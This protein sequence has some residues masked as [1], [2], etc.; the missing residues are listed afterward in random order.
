M[1]VI[2][3]HNRQPLLTCLRNVPKPGVGRTMIPHSHGSAMRQN[4]QTE[5][6]YRFP[7]KLPVSSVLSF[8][9]LADT[10]SVP[11]AVAGRQDKPQCQLILYD[12]L[13]N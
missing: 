1:G 13:L 11:L 2:F 9:P 8:L 4:T 7:Q 5:Q 3:H 12:L 10:T 6:L